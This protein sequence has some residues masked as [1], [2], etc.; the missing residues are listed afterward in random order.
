LASRTFGIGA[1]WHDATIPT[2]DADQVG[3]ANR[4][5][6]RAH[7]DV[8][9]AVVVHGIA[10]L[11]RARM[12]CRVLV[13]A[14]RR[15]LDAPQRAVPVLIHVLVD[16]L[17]AVV[18]DA[19]AGLGCEAHGLA[20]AVYATLMEGKARVYPARRDFTPEWMTT[21]SDRRASEEPFTQDQRAQENKERAHQNVISKPE[22]VSEARTPG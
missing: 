6:G 7:I 16:A 19:I 20:L 12:D 17:V 13:V 15:I 11:G 9:V 10:G 8:T 18:V 22:P 4:C 5:V 1:A 21:R 3:L 2:G 14:V